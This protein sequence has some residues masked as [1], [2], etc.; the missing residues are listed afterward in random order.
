MTLYGIDYLNDLVKR[1][2][3]EAKCLLSDAALVIFSAGIQHA[4]AGFPSITYRDDHTG[5]ALAG[6]V[7]SGQVELRYHRAYSDNR[8]TE[9]WLRL[10]ANPE[11]TPLRSFTVTYQGRII[12]E[13]S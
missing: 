4:Q 7:K 6:T 11:A 10:A 9:L 13:K 1:P 5:N 2:H 12:R 3:W 8:V